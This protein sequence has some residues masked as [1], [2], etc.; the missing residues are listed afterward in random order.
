MSTQLSVNPAERIIQKLATDSKFAD[1]NSMFK[2]EKQ[3]DKFVRSFR[4]LTATNPAILQTDQSSLFLSLYKAAH[5]GLIVDGV[6]ATLVVYNTKKGNDWVN[7]AQYI[8]MVKGVRDKVYEFTG[9]LIDAQVVYER[10]SFEWEQG[11]TPRLKHVPSLDDEPGKPIAV[12]AVAK[13]KE[14]HV[15]DRTVMRIS[16]VNAIREKSKSKNKDGKIVGPWVDNYGEMAKKTAVKRLA[17]YLPLPEEVE[18]II[19]RD[20]EMYEF[21]TALPSSAS[22]GY[23]AQAIED[24]KSLSETVDMETGEILQP[25]IDPDSDPEVYANSLKIDIIGWKDKA[26]PENYRA[27]VDKF[28]ANNFKGLPLE[29]LEKWHAALAKLPE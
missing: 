18:D 1:F 9:M 23:L 16:E 13:T 10:D 27:T 14:G 8:P 4:L 25:D 20:N 2:T 3:R 15:V 7:M 26:M 21:K 11:D 5:D 24:K 12:Y 28:I 19:A 29:H 6:K 22:S 17:K